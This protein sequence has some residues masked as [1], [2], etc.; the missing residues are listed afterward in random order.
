MAGLYE[1]PRRLMF[2]PTVEA[3]FR[4]T[5]EESARYGSTDFGNAVL[6]ARK[7]VEQDQ[8]TRFI[9][10]DSFGWD[11]H[12]AIY[13]AA[14]PRSIFAQTKEFDPAF[15]ALIE[16]L[17]ASGKLADTLVLA[18]GEFG[19]TP[20]NLSGERNGRDH[21]LQMFFVLA[22]DGVQGGKVIGATNDQGGRG[23]GAF[24]TEAGWYRDREI[25][26]EDIETTIFSALG[27]DWAK[28]RNDDP[29]GRGFCY[30]PLARDGACTP[31]REL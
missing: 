1:D 17:D 7:I 12:A 16:D 9:Q 31:V 26:P 15:A 28:S 29:L 11:H 8:G 18:C 19:R 23:P 21:Y 10:I 14:A 4:F 6:P 20:G 30:L 24:T 22:G 13:D 27:I 25:R 2:N 5:P 3:A